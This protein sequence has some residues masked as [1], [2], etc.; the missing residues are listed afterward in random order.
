MDIKQLQ[1]EARKCF[2]AVLSM[3]AADMDEWYLSNVGY[4]LSVDCPGLLITDLAAQTAGMMFFHTVPAGLE[5]PGAEMVE[6]ILEHVITHGYD[7]DR[8][9]EPYC[10]LPLA[11][12][13]IAIAI[14]RGELS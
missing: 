11:Q 12:R 2:L 1:G 14:E 3:T 5:E 8:D 9:R 4:R 13:A 10:N 7:S 6:R